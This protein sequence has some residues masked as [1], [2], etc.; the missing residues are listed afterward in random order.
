MR[1]PPPILRALRALRS[2]VSR[3]R[4]GPRRS[5]SPIASSA[6]LLLL[7]AAPAAAAD[8][9]VSP[10]RIELS[11]AQPTALMTIR[12]RGDDDTL[13]QLSIVSWA[14]NGTDEV[15]DPTRD[16]LANPGVF[17]LK[18]GEQQVARFGLRVPPDV[19]ERSY[20]IIVQEVPRQHLQNTVATVLRI[21]VPA[22]VPTAN[23]TVT[24]DWNVQR[25]P[26][27]LFL[28]VHNSGNVHAQIKSVTLT[29]EHGAPLQKSLNMY[30]LPGG[31]RTTMFPTAKPDAVGAPIRVSADSDQ[32]SYTASIRVG[33][34]E[35][36]SGHS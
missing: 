27:G 12:N 14:Q 2:I 30:V 28:T 1:T 23:P 24:L 20:R 13:L 10:T 19:K 11:A 18:G 33:A 3:L 4:A 25:M 34:S 29:G 15:M 9:Q 26:Q 31:T 7:A 8:L 32:G 5:A 16:V 17:L 36:A 22:F 21:I 35:G 6:A